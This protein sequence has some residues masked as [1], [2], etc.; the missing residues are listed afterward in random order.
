MKTPSYFL[1]KMRNAKPHKW[2]EFND[3]IYLSLMPYVL[4]KLPDDMEIMVEHPG[5]Y[6]SVIL[7]DNS[8]A[9]EMLN[10]K[11][12]TFSNVPASEDDWIFSISDRTIQDIQKTDCASVISNTTSGYIKFDLKA[13]LHKNVSPEF[14]VGPELDFKSQVRI[15]SK[16]FNLERE[17]YG[18]FEIEGPYEQPYMVYQNIED[19]RTTIHHLTKYFQRVRL[20]ASYDSI[21]EGIKNGSVDKTHFLS[22]IQGV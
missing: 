17:L 18:K 7:K 12:A 9:V 5:C 13:W 2:G 3:N 8:F 22:W 16:V 1:E 14:A 4:Y 11:K 10:P 21:F 6:T 20:P 19:L 15:A